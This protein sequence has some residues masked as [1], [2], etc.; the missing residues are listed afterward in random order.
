[1]DALRYRTAIFTN[2]A[3][4]AG[5]SLVAASFLVMA[6]TP[7]FATFHFAHIERILT[8]LDGNTDVQF[9]QI[10]MEASSQQFVEGAQLIAFDAEGNFSHVVLVLDKDVANGG[11]GKSFLMA[12]TAFE[13]ETG[14][15]PDFVFSTAGGNALPAEAGM[16]C[17]GKPDDETDPD[18]PD[19]VDCVSY[20]NYTGPDNSHTDAPSPVTPF[21]HGLARVQDTG[22]SAA[23]FECEDPATAITN[24]P[25]KVG[26]AATTPCPGAAACGNGTVEEPETCDDGDTDFTPGDFCSATCDDF[27]CGVPTSATATVPKTSDALF[28]LRAGV[29]SAA[30]SPVVCDVNGSGDVNASD[31]LAVLRKAVGQQVIFDCPT[32]L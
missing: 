15:A 28:V 30:C 3:S 13:E 19:M 20:G 12:S 32:L 29:G 7:A 17:W 14:L 16:V 21:G 9:V 10:E 1:M 11:A 27:A 2:R 26:V 22:S 24:E 25:D 6:A 18:D 5:S 31:A 4:R 23:D 8:G